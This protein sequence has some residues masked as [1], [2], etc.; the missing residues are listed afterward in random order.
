MAVVSV[1][2]AQPGMVLAAEVV[3]RKG[4]RL[5]PAEAELT[6]RHVQAL[7]MWGIPHIEIEGEAE[8]D[9]LPTVS[10]EVEQKLRQEVEERFGSA[11]TSHPFLAALVTFATERS[12]HAHVS[13]ES[14]A[15]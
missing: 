11:E 2:R 1:E 7:K 12:I 10:P 14:A 15:P 5:I 8:D 13:K 6:E 4:R 9:S 3:D